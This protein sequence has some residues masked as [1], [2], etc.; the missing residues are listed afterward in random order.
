MILIQKHSTADPQKFNMQLVQSK[1]EQQKVF[2]QQTAL[3]K[4]REIVSATS[5]PFKLTEQ[6]SAPGPFV[7]KTGRGIIQEPSESQRLAQRLR[8]QEIRDSQTGFASGTAFVTPG[9]MSDP[10]AVAEAQSVQRDIVKVREATREKEF[11]KAREE[12]DR[13]LAF[14]GNRLSG[15]V[16]PVQQEKFR[17]LEEAR[18]IVDPIVK[19]KTLAL[20]KQQELFLDLQAERDLE[21]EKVL[22]EEQGFFSKWKEK[23]L[24]PESDTLFLSEKD[25]EQ[26]SKER[27]LLDDKISDYKK[28]EK[29][30]DVSFD[31]L[32]A[33]EDEVIGFTEQV[34]AVF[35]DRN[36]RIEALEKAEAGLSDYQRVAVERFGYGIKP[37][38][39]DY[40]PVQRK[41]TGDLFG[42]TKLFKETVLGEVPKQS[43]PEPGD[44]SGLKTYTG[45]RA[46]EEK[47]FR[48]FDPQVAGGK[49]VGSTVAL[50]GVGGFLG[51]SVG[52]SIPILGTG[53]G[54]VAGAIVGAK[55]GFVAGVSDVLASETVG[56]ITGSDEWG[57]RAGFVAGFVGAGLAS[58]RFMG[59]EIVKRTTTVASQPR[60]VAS[61]TVS[62]EVVPK[63]L[64]RSKDTKLAKVFSQQTIN[65][66]VTASLKP[67]TSRLNTFVQKMV[68][69]VTGKQVS[70]QAKVLGSKTVSF[71]VVTKGDVGAVLT[72]TKFSR[73][74]AD[75]VGRTDLVVGGPKDFFVSGGKTQSIFV[76]KG[77]LGERISGLFVRPKSG[78]SSG[79]NRFIAPFVETKKS[80]GEKVLS[81]VRGEKVVVSRFK[82][83]GVSEALG[84]SDIA[85]VGKA[86]IT[87]FVDRVSTSV[88][89]PT[90]VATR[91]SVDPRI[92][93]GKAWVGGKQNLVEFFGLYTKTGA[94]RGFVSGDAFVRDVPLQVYAGGSTKVFSKS[95]T[96]QQAS[97]LLGGFGVEKARTFGEVSVVA[98]KNITGQNVA[99]VQ[100]MVTRLD[101][102]RPLVASADVGSVTTSG[103][104][105][106]VSGRTQTLGLTKSQTRALGQVKSLGVERVRATI[107]PRFKTSTDYLNVFARPDTRTDSIFG[108]EKLRTGFDSFVRTG[109]TQS[110]AFAQPVIEKVVVPVRTIE[111]VRLKPSQKIDLFPRTVSPL[112]PPV[113]FIPITG[114]GG[115]VPGFGRMDSGAGVRGFGRTTSTKRS[116]PLFQVKSDL[117]RK[118]VTGE[119]DLSV[120]RENVA[121]IK[122]IRGKKGSLLGIIPTKEL[123]VKK[124]KKKKGKW[125]D[126]EENAWG[127]G[128][129]L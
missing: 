91:I 61:K 70:S 15:D 117:F 36:V 24:D 27:A 9:R 55:A 92:Y 58:S 52:S 6:D 101:F 20:Q 60:V 50:A 63:G 89:G 44:V 67:D 3:Q 109:T 124:K 7:Q 56:R 31:R 116:S 78:V 95:M 114:S 11:V 85:Q 99:A 43:I 18:D 80:L 69:S 125:F 57:G 13:F 59:K 93:V 64:V 118:F 38:E 22:G 75:A 28:L 84:F 112:P 32:K 90:P 127:G 111:R 121:L 96:L 39:F 30:Y 1:A 23:D 42:V 21:F 34:D 4:K 120:S 115:M 16:D 123:L 37:F 77:T 76:Q 62:L 100:K 126:E 26:Y 14:T 87:D 19:Q 65:V 25:F 51:S 97:D 103:V 12:A 82:E 79:F 48:S 104:A 73:V 45:R 119:K 8:L 74:V 129:V 54:A 5:G 98:A 108:V 29:R 41:Q 17:S 83:K 72:G 49:I 2:R 68:S 128:F 47:V 107:V 94:K 113:P 71:D 46:F 81:V 86:R 106:L 53:V 10:R 35:K 88:M 66:D 33:K 105:S 102:S 40:S 110:F 122:S